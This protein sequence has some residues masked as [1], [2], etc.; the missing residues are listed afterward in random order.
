MERQVRG[1]GSGETNERFRGRLELQYEMLKMDGE[2]VPVKLLNDLASTACC[3]YNISGGRQF[4]SLLS[5]GNFLY[6]IEKLQESNIHY[7]VV[8]F[9]ILPVLGCRSQ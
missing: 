1:D 9:G 8:V 7:G 5:S 3:D 6:G 4:S 2:L